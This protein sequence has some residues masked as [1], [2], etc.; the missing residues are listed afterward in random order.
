MWNELTEWIILI[1]FSKGFGFC[2][3]QENCI[4]VLEANRTIVH[5]TKDRLKI[6]NWKL[7]EDKLMTSIW[8]KEHSSISQKNSKE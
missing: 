1:K 4:E 6:V 3:P 5:L 8:T 7:I 2:K